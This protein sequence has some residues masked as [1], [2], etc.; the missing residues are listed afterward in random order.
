ME[1]GGRDATCYVHAPDRVTERRDA[2]RQRATEFLRRE[3]MSDAAPGP[4][5]GAVEPAD[6][7]LGPL[8]SVGATARIDD[9]RVDRPDV[10]DVELV[11]LSDAGHEVGQEDVGGLGDLVEH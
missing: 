5:G 2:L 6:V 11:P 4:K 8:V 7:A 10:L 3:G 1:Q 9:V